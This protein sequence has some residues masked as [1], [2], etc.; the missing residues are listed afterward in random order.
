MKKLLK[1]A[2]SIAL[3]AIS[4]YFLN[5][6][7]LL[8]SIKKLDPW[9][10]ILALVVCFMHFI[11]MGIRWHL[12]VG[13][14]VSFSFAQNLKMYLYAT[15]LNTFTP[16]NLGGD[17][18]RL[19][20][21]KKHADGFF[22]VLSSLIKEKVLGLLAFLLLYI[23]CFFLS[24][25][26]T[27]HLLEHGSVFNIAAI[28]ICSTLV[29]IGFLPRLINLLASK[30]YRFIPDKVRDILI[31]IRYVINFESWGYF[32]KLTML[33]LLGALF[34]VATVKI[35]AS[36]LEVHI[37]WLLL[38]MV[39]TLVEIIRF[40]PITIQGIGLR[41]GAYAYLFVVLGMSPEDGFVLGAV[42]YAIL[43]VALLVSGVISS[44]MILDNVVELGET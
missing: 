19:V 27:P 14:I 13:C 8:A 44:L 30:A 3:L 10:F 42:S 39:A 9:M 17:A 43:C 6:E 35:V 16:A 40:V 29:V 4:I 15:F 20:L 26:L 38:A 24:R 34:W 36:S 25:I 21:L 5:L 37:S 1:I 41:E 23:S 2:A 33:S 11:L 28:L 7:Q 32:I 31:S 22:P 12:I 18:Y